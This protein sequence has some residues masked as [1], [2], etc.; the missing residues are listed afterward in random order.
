MQD[1]HAEWTCGM[2]IRHGHVHIYVHIHIHTY[3]RFFTHTW[4][5]CICIHVYILICSK[6]FVSFLFTDF[7]DEISPNKNEKWPWQ[8]KISTKQK[9]LF[10][11]NHSYQ[12]YHWIGLGQYIRTK[13]FKYEINKSYHPF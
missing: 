7:F 11:G 6:N 12:W 5:Y 8:N 13:L 2:N 1:G 9:S 10:R 3:T 4:T